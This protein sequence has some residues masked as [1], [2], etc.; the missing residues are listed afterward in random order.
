MRGL[1]SQLVEKHSTMEKMLQSLQKKGAEI[2]ELKSKLDGK[3]AAQWLAEEKKQDELRA[4]EAAWK[5][6]CEHGGG[7]TSGI[8]LSLRL[9]SQPNEAF[10]SSKNE[11]KRLGAKF[12]PSRKIWYVPANTLLY[13]FARWL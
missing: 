7:T 8:S 4:G 2:T 5:A 1:R 12:D 3:I 11:V 10:V 13:A 9:P 6:W